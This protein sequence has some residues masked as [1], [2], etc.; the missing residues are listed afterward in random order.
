MSQEPI[1]VTQPVLPE[2]AEFIPYLEQIWNNK[3]FNQLWT[4]TSTV[5]KRAL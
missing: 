2:L 3:V 1:Y 5:G 4:I